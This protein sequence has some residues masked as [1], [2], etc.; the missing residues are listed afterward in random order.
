M[1][2]EFLNFYQLFK[3]TIANQPIVPLAIVGPAALAGAAWFSAKTQLPYDLTL[4]R[5]LVG[6]HITIAIKEK[7][8]EINL[9]Y[10]LEQHATTKSTADN[11]FL[12]YEGK[13]WTFKEIYDTVLKYGTWLKTTYAVAPREVVA[14]D[15]MNSPQFV[16]MW[17][18]LWSIGAIPAF[19]NYNLTEDPLLHSLKS[20][21]ARLLFVDPEVKHQFSQKVTD[22]L[23]SPQARD[24][25]GPIQTVY[26][27]AALE[28]K[29]LSLDGVREPDLARTAMR[30]D[31]CLLI[32]TS[33]TTGLPKPANVSWQKIRLL[34][35]FVPKWL[36]QKKTDRY[37]T[38][39]LACS[40]RMLDSLI[41]SVHASLSLLCG[42]HGLL[43][44]S[45]DQQHYNHRPPL[46][47]TNLLA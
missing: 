12:V 16:F 5:A 18:G 30:L 31:T 36:G 37:Y 47:H 45:C 17:L 33:G 23:S 22:A 25:K 1:A 26:F 28:Q 11:T 32:F 4:I 9:F 6:A 38:V 14:M 27:D 43:H 8:G 10:A 35:G 13:T 19:I 44:F 29:I 21:T 2:S 40:F 41:E 24:G 7:R 20:S 42:F 46:L 3:G 39:S 15:F 34:T